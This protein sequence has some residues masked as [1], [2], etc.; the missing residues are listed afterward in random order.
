MAPYSILLVD[1]EPELLDV[2]REALEDEGYAVRTASNGVEGLALLEAGGL[3]LVVSD[4][5]MP[6]LDGLGL[7]RKVAELSM[8]VE[9]IFLTGYGTVENAVECLK[10]GAA[11]FLL[12]PFGLDQLRGAVRKALREREMKLGQRK[13]GNLVRML[14]LSQAL[15]D[16]RDLRG[17]VREFL[18][19]VRKAFE[20]EGIA[21]FFS[22]EIGPDLAPGVQIGPF[23]KR[24][25]ARAWFATLSESLLRQGRPK[26]LDPGAMGQALGQSLGAEARVSA[27]AAPLAAGLSGAGVVA[28]L[29]GPDRQPYTLDDLQLLTVFAS[30]A[31][32]CFESFSACSRLSAMNEEIVTSFVNAVEAKD[33][34]TGGHSSRVSAYAERLGRALSLSPEELSS[35]CRAATLHDI[36]KIG[37][38]DQ[39]LNKA[40]ALTPE[41]R[42]VIRRHPVV[43]RDILA[44]VKSLS[45]ML[46]MIYHHH[47]R[48]DGRG[49]PAGLAG[50]DIP[51]AARIISVVDGYEAMTSD[52]AYQRARSR[53]EALAILTSGAGSQWDPDL[54]RT[55]VGLA[56]DGDGR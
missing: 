13:V 7:I 51:L 44:K 10:L 33:R 22:G 8:E 35:L 17:L 9:V 53:E 27:M 6:R 15:A 39:I 45:G 5:R 54:V 43:G 46:P 55:W 41:E 21:L 30:H 14:N 20:P 11:D 28:A 38:P 2:C 25:E 49:Y 34:Y 12:K 47:E 32:S 24:P 40:A 4:L 36:G 29:R 48:F 1:D 23:F 56:R 26:L 19:Q 3:D 31:S 50:P 42:A 37:V 18:D 16:R 52:R